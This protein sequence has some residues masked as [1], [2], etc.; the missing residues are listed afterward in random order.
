EKQI[1]IFCLS[2]LFGQVV[3][4]LS[5]NLD[6]ILLRGILKEPQQVGYY[7]AGI[8][9]PKIIETMF[10]SQIPTPFLYYFTS[11]ETSHL[12]EKIL[13]F[14]SKM[15]GFLFGIVGL[16]LFTF[17]DYIIPFLFSNKFIESS[18]VFGFFSL[19]LPVLAFLILIS[20]FYL[21]QNKP[22]VFVIIHLFTMVIFYNLMNIFLIP[23][24]KFFAP[25][26]SYL[27]SLVLFAIIVCI[28]CYRRYKLNLVFNLVAIVTFL[29]F[30]VTLERIF[31]I[32][33]LAFLTFI[34]VCFLTNTI[35][36]QD[37]SKFRFILMKKL[38]NENP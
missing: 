12:K 6:I 29:F 13:I 26:I 34:L 9:I 7:S 17:S 3:Y 18:I 25:V 2:L 37:F 10:I 5:A 35:S 15:L 8:R 38:E 23:K 31:N 32:K 4:M 36:I 30:V 33:L 20:P 16:V 24:Y 1:I 19:S 14:S 11:T 28:D 21:S 22:Y 27:L